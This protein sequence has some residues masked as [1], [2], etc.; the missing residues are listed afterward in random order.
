MT[1]TGTSAQLPGHRLFTGIAELYTPF[2]RVED[3][4]LAVEEGKV[5]WVGPR[6]RLP[7]GY[8][9]WPVHDL[10]GRAVVPGLVDSHTHLVWAGDRGDEYRLRSHGAAYEEI[11]QAGGGIHSTVAATV[12][13]TEEE[14]LELALNRAE[15]FLAGGVTTLEVKSGYGGELEQE[16]KMLRVIRRLA[17]T[18]PQQVV[19]TLLAHVI[20]AGWE[21]ERYV[22]AFV[23]ELIPAVSEANLA[24]AVDVFCDSGAFTLDETRRIFEAAL[25]SGLQIK[26]HAEQ[27]SHSGATAL[28]A[29]LGGLSADHL[30]EA[31]EEDWQALAQAGTVGTIL[32]GATVLL[33]KPFPD[34]RRM[35][36]AG[37]KVAVASDHNP[38]SSPFYSLFLALQLTVALGGLSVEEVLIAGTAHAAD[39]L[40]RPG[41]GRL[42]PG[43]DADFLVTA[44]PHATGPL[45]TW[46]VT[47][48]SAVYSGGEPVWP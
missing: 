5:A 42:E 25:E 23:S 39:A 21:R 16:L 13:A 41:L 27:L 12:E 35:W 14:L 20:P 19:P 4:A 22:D 24:G 30:E 47:R 40:G 43:S 15:I 18:V 11:L 29:E 32:P 26:A 1:D 44:T 33:R 2:D 46:G 38:G 31:T 48:L 17:E 10:G 34:A 8:A 9:D 6:D 45:Y 28:V 3:A 36:D 7:D 37:V